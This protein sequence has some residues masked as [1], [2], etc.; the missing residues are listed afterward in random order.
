MLSLVESCMQNIKEKVI[1]DVH[2]RKY[3]DLINKIAKVEYRSMGT[4]HLVEFD[5]LINIGF[6]IIYHFH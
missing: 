4:Q 6:Q 5:E 2:L 3:S 1:K